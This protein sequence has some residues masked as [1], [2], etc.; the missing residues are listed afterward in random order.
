MTMSGRGSR[1]AASLRRQ[2]SQHDDAC[3]IFRL[4]S[5]LSSGP[6]PLSGDNSPHWSS[7]SLVLQTLRSPHPQGR[8]RPHITLS[9]SFS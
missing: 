1:N 3:I 5:G 6:P 7:I 9:H 2:V 8:S 4:L